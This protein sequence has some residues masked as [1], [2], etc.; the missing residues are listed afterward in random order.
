[1]SEKAKTEEVKTVKVKLRADHTHAGMKYSAG[2]EIEVTEQDAEWLLQVK[3]A[4]SVASKTTTI[5]SKN[6]NEG[7]QNA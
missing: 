2:K 5:A 4:E 6:V 3:V 1:M 7:Q